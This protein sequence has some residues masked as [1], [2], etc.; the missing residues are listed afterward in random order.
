[1]DHLKNPYSPGAGSPP[2]H[3]VGRELIL[4]QLKILLERGQPG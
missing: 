2:P 1:M 3:L 4:E